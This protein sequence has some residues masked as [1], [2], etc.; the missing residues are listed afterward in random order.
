MDSHALA[1]AAGLFDG[2]GCTHYKV[3]SKRSRPNLVISIGQID[4]QVLDRFHEA[5]GQGTVNGPYRHGKWAPMYQFQAFGLERCEE[6]MRLL[7]PWLGDV[8]REQFE[9][10]RAALL[11]VRTDFVMLKGPRC[12]YGHEDWAETPRGRVCRTCRQ[13]RNREYRQRRRQSAGALSL[14]R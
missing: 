5:V 11:A 12:R 1:W 10:G 7:W 8:K 4:R 6:I 9:A 2:E 3:E 13:K 14:A